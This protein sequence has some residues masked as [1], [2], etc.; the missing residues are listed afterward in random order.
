MDFIDKIN[1]LSERIL[2]LKDQI[3]TEEA[4]KTAFIMPFIQALEYDVFNPNELIPEFIADI[5]TK[6]GEKVDYAIV[7]DNKPKI[8]IECKCCGENLDKHNSQLYR[9]YSC[10]DARFAIITDGIIYKFY[11]E[12]EEKNKLDSKPFF[13]FN[14]LDFDEIQVNELKK[15][16]K[17]KF[18]EETITSTAS[19][20]KYT[21]EIKNLLSAEYN[22]P[23]EEFIRLF[24]KKVYDGILNKQN[25][26]KFERLTH[27]AFKQFVN[28]LMNERFKSA[29]VKDTTEKENIIENK[30]DKEI[31]TTVQELEGFAIIKSILRGKVELERIFY[32]DN[33]SY[34]NIL[35]DN[36]IRKTLCRL[37]FNKKQKYI[38][39]I[40]ENKKEN[41]ISIENLDAIYNHSE[42][43]EKSLNNIIKS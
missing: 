20:L 40:D 25:L 13:I 22:N 33:F 11:T 10:T 42:L 8:L 39:F 1:D 36:N 24:A 12:L 9:Y 23:S 17:T 32:R 43:I 26:E 37:Y 2:K 5:G 34:F 30:E 15:F 7:L 29:L 38:A 41:K 6:K 31:T 14:M 16:C 3:K 28:E 27:K 21:R 4:T 19:E 35:L 18:D